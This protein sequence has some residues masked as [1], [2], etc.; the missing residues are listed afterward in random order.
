VDVLAV[1]DALADPPQPVQTMAVERQVANKHSEVIC[2]R[3]ERLEVSGVCM[4]ESLF[5]SSKAAE[6][7][8]RVASG[9]RIVKG[10]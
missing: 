8:G 1:E 10:R 6:R 3:L 9:G 5:Y 7:K 4:V 2:V